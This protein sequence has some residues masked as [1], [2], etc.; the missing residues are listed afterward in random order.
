MTMLSG[1]LIGGLLHPALRRDRFRRNSYL[2]ALALL[3]VAFVSPL[4]ALSS[5]LF[6]ARVTHHLLLISAAAPL[7]AVAFP[8]HFRTTGTPLTLAILA[9]VVAVWFWHAPVPYAWALGSDGLYWVMQASLLGTAVLVWR[10]LLTPG[11]QLRSSIG[12]VVLISLMGLLGALITFAPVP[13]YM[14]HLLTTEL[15][16]LTPLE[17]QQLAGLIM[18]VPAIVPNL[19][20]ALVCL[21][22]L[23]EAGGAKTVG[24]A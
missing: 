14:P 19:V 2:G 10:E 3:T 22:G 4:C 24:R 8:A 15:Y 20:A 17:D 9:H 21:L 18:W 16:G 5:A 12:H 6:S 23:A 13:L 11:V 7:L 1:V